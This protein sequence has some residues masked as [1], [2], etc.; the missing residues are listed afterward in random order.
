MSLL[1]ETIRVVGRQPLHLEYHTARLNRSRRE[2]FDCTDVIDLRKVLTVPDS[3]GEGIHRCRV[4]YEKKIEQIEF[5][6]YERR[7]IRSLTLVE[8]DTIE[9]AHKFLDRTAIDTLRRGITTDDILIVKDGHI[10]DT[11][12]A[13]IVFHDGKRWVTPSTPLLAG[14]ARA[15]LL[16]EGVITEEEITARSLARFTG[17]AAINAMVDLDE[18]DVIGMD[19]IT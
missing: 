15:R 2:L 13:N 16:R 18:A 19:Q 17:A 14:T 7:P 5:I 11:S 1:F 12:I 8:S 10:T 9:Y 6:A 3:L 4:V